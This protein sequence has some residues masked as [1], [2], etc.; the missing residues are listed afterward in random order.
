L[1]SEGRAGFQS[2]EGGGG[3]PPVTALWRA[4]AARRACAGANA[5]AAGGQGRAGDRRAQPD[6]DRLA[7][8]SVRSEAMGGSEV[9]DPRRIVAEGYDDAAERYA[10]LESPDAPWPRVRR[11]LDLL[12]RLPASAD[13]IDL[14]CGSGIPALQIMSESHTVTGVEI[15]RVQAELARRNA[16]AARIIRGGMSD[17]SFAPASFDAIT[18]FYVVDHLPRDEHSHLF[19]R[20]N[21]W[22]R[23]NGYLLFTVEPY[24]EPGEVREWEGVPMFF[25]QFDP[26]TTLDLVADAGFNVIS[27]E[28]E[29]QLEGSQEVDFLWVLAQ[30]L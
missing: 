8:T 23:P 22:L 2:S 1:R 13:V 21:D 20:F 6:G 14:G 30:R 4:I 29:T 27:H 26:T 28:V 24:D 10:A 16:P 18:A 25:S 5:G 9:R 11:L 12:A 3:S 15:S 7:L 19:R 17:V